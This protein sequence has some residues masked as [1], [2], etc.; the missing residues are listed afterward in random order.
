LQSNR[1]YSIRVRASISGVFGNFGNACT[2]G[3]A[4]G[5]RED[6]AE[7]V[8]DEETTFDENIFNLNVYPNPF[9][10][11]ANLFIQATINDKAQVQIFDMM[12]NLVWDRQV[13]TNEN[14][15]LGNEFANGNYFI[16]V[17]NQNGQHTSFR[18]VKAN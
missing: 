18:I 9:S 12:G 4:S 2:I 6:V 5:T 15:A 14:I 10:Q 16:N 17:F 1:Q 3:F 11:Q 13:N 7:N 8:T